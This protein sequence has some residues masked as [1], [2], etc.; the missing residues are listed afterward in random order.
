MSIVVNDNLDI[1][2]AALAALDPQGR[3]AILGLRDAFL[4]DP[5]G[6]AA[7][8]GSWASFL[9]RLSRPACLFCGNT[10]PDVVV[11]GLLQC[12]GCGALGWPPEAVAASVEN[13]FGE[14]E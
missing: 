3:E 6:V 14:E 4:R 7:A 11:G 13:I 10:E 5:E 12:A 8:L 1:D 2:P 9:R